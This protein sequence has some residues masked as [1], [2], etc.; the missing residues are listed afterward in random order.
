VVANLEG[1]AGGDLS[2]N[3]N[4]E[5]RLVVYHTSDYALF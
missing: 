3:F 2:F 1:E 5:G 4:S